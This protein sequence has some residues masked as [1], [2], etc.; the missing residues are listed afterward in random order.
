MYIDNFQGKR[1][2]ELATELA[3]NPARAAKAQALTL[4]EDKPLM[5]LLGDHGLFGSREWWQ[6]IDQGRIEVRVYKG[7]ITR[8][9]VAGQDADEEQGKDFE[10][11]C[12]DKIIRSASCVAHNDDDLELYRE[13]ANVALA[14]ALEKLKKQPSKDG[15]VNLTEVL[16]EVVIG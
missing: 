11:V 10:Y 4:N 7:T 13:G 6:S 9:Y 1:V 15:G 16:L 12:D 2:Y 5:G 8:L 14:Y 3:A